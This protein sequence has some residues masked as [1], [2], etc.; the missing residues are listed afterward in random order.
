MPGLVMSERFVNKKIQDENVETHVR[1]EIQFS[2]VSKYSLSTAVFQEIDTAAAR[3]E[4]TCDASSASI[5]GSVHAAK[6]IAFR[7]SPE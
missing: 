4:R 2:E 3:S 5:I 6:C 7:H 1:R